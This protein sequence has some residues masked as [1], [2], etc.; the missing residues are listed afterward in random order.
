M[1][2]RIL[3]MAMA[4]VCALT[5]LTA[6][7]SK[8]QSAPAQEP[9]FGADLTAFYNDIMNA[10][11][12][13][14][15]MMDLAAD[16][17]LLEGMYPGLAAVE[18][19]QLV[20]ASPAMSAVAIE[21]AFAEMANAADVE[22]VKTIFQTRID[23]QVDGG[24]WY[25]ET[26]EGWKNNSE[27][28][29]IDNYVCM[30]VC[31]EK[32]G[33]IEALRNGTEVP[34]WAKAQESTEDEFQGDVG[35][36]DMPVMDGPAAYDPAADMPGADMPAAA[37]VAPEEMP[38]EQEPAVVEPAPGEPVEPAAPA[39]GASVDLKAFYESILASAGENAP[40][41]MDVVMDLGV[42]GIE[43]LYPGL[44][45]IAAN[46][47]V[48]YMPAMSA[49]ACEIAMIEC[50]NAADVEAVKAIFQ[51]RIDAQVD[52]GA[53]YPETIRG[54]EENSDIVVNGNY[55]AMFVIPE[56]MMDAASEFGKLF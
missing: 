16:A 36:M 53:W 5:M 46:Q 24:A 2:K 38:V 10:A 48:I 39:A 40:F 12:E 31:A 55:V 22:T 56:G 52:G 20:V 25:P 7:G 51:A 27:I 32:D 34:A 42:E 21:F 6:C 1:N 3:A 11:E 8:E 4:V 45:A 37:P 23:T 43:M 14:P 41:M 30:F 33:M 17:E 47:Q 9:S 28:V 15:F 26:I 29:V 54:W 44:S 19:K 49:V 50:T 18:T 35:I 13:G